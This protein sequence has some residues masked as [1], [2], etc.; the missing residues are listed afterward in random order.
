MT[1]GFFALQSGEGLAKMLAA[2][3]SSGPSI[4]PHPRHNLHGLA[5]ML[6]GLAS[7]L[8]GLADMIGG[9]ADMPGGGAPGAPSGEVIA[10]KGRIWGDPHFIGADGGKYDVQGEAGKTYNLLSDKGFQ[11]NGRFDAWGSGGA[12]VVG[13]VGINADGDQVT[14]KGNG[15]VLVNGMAVEKGERVE[16]ANGGFV[17]NNGNK[18]KVESG[19]WKVDF[20]VQRGFLNMDVS[21]DNAVADGVKPHGLLGQTF[22]GDGEARNGDKGR[23]AQGGGAI[24]GLFGDISDKGG[25]KHHQSV[26][27]ERYPRDGLRCSQPVLRGRRSGFWQSRL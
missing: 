13:E 7:M 18:V 6:D 20:Q 21:T 22:D 11:M 19:E 17:E 25:Q 16:L 27:G 4:M 26:S 1:I 8:D 14:V 3:R 9:I 2:R 12:T 10:G 15:D 24:E 5:K 23:G